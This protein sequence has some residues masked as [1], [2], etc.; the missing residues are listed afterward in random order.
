V[1]GPRQRPDL[2]IHK[3]ARLI[4]QDRSVPLYGDGS[5]RRDYTYVDDIVSGIRAAMD[6]TAS[7]YEVFNLGN[8]RTVSLLEM[9][10]VIEDA[11]G[12][13]AV[14]DRQPEQPGDVPQTYADIGKARALLNYEPATDFRTGISRF[15]S[16]LA[17][18]EPHS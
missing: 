1:Y 17:A 16:W 11:L 12:A 10:S 9:I 8:H 6:Y 13:R 18:C 2:A 4:R 7:G 15:V 5:T 14:L 3:F